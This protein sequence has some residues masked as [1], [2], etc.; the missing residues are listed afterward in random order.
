MIGDAAPHAREEAQTLA[1][2]RRYAA[3]GP[4]RSVSALFIDTPSYRRFG[5]GDRGF[6][7]QLAQSGRG[8]FNRHS[9]EMIE[10]VL[11]SVLDSR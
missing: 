10:S 7:A 6:F 3:N 11:L 8:Q 9:G 4:E 5:T 2:A 1:L